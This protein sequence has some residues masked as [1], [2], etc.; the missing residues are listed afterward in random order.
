MRHGDDLP[1]GAPRGA[2]T[3]G[4]RKEV[5]LDRRRAEGAAAPGDRPEVGIDLMSDRMTGSARNT[6]KLTAGSERDT[7]PR[8]VPEAIARWEGEGGRP[9]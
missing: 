8:S 1:Q 3:F 5:E 9:C 4:E 7:A 6:S 2:R